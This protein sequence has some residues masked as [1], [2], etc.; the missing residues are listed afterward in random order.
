MIR[1]ALTALVGLAVL[2]A[3]ACTTQAISIIDGR[4]DRQVEKFRYP[5]VI[6]AVDGVYSTDQRRTIAPGDH[7]LVLSSARTTS[8][9]RQQHSFPLRTEACRQY[10]LAAQH[11]DATS[12]RWTL[13]VDRVWEIPNCDPGTTA[14]IR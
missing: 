4:Y 9:N 6:H 14:E 5:V 10:R 1:N 3:S 7:I 8:P 2:S 13:V 12:D 11:E